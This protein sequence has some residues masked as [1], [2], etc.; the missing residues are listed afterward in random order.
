MGFYLPWALTGSS[1]GTIA[2][3]LYSTLD[4]TTSVGKW[5]GYQIIGGVGNGSAASS[6]RYVE[7]RQHCFTDPEQSYIA[8]QNTVPRASIPTAMAILIL[9]QNLGA[10]VFLTIAQTILNT[11]LGSAITKDAPGVD[12]DA[13]LTGGAT[14]VRKIVSAQKL[15]G[16]LQAYSTA[17]DSVMYLGIGLGGLAFVCAWGLGWKDIRKK[18]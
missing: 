9:C 2:Y 11:S 18:T 10:A 1:L 13:V 5:I 8:I 4:T 7:Q 3:G 16:V 6:V 17:I 15:P 12:A 14:M